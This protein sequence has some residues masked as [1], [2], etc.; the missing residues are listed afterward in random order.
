MFAG[1]AFNLYQMNVLLAMERKYI[2]GKV[3]EAH[4]RGPG[5]GTVFI[6]STQ[7]IIEA[8]VIMLFYCWSS[9]LME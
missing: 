2:H 3:Y 1:K 4:G 9:Y 5:Q 7:K 8:E 6:T